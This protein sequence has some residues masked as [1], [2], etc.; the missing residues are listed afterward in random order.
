MV[1]CFCVSIPLVG[2]EGHSLGAGSFNHANAAS[3]VK[4]AQHPEGLIFF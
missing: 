1:R 2:E 3:G 4:V